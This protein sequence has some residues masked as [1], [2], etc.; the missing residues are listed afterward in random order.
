MNKHILSYTDKLNESIGKGSVLLIK[1]KPIKDGRYLYVTT[2]N[3]W[4]EIKPGIKMVFI[5]DNI[6]RVIHKG[7][8][9]FS[10]RKVQIRDEESLKGVFNMKNPGK[11][12]LVLN[13]NKTPFHWMTLKHTD[14]GTALRELGTQLFNHEMILESSQAISKEEENKFFVTELLKKLAGQPSAIVI[15]EVELEDDTILEFEDAASQAEDSYEDDWNVIF[16]VLLDD[17]KLSEPHLSHFSDTEKIE[18]EWEVMNQMGVDLEIPDIILSFNTQAYV[19]HSRDEGDYW[20]PPSSET[21]VSDV[22]TTLNISTIDAEEY[23]KLRS[24]WEKVKS[25][26]QDDDQFNERQKIA[27]KLNSYSFPYMYDESDTVVLGG[28]QELKNLISIIERIIDQD[29][30]E[31]T[32]SLFEG[33][34]GLTSNSDKLKR[35]VEARGKYYKQRLDLRQ[36]GISEEDKKKWINISV[37]YAKSVE[38]ETVKLIEQQKEMEQRDTNDETNSITEEDIKRSEE[39]F[40]WLESHIPAISNNTY[41]NFKYAQRSWIESEKSWKIPRLHEKGVIAAIGYLNKVVQDP[42]DH[43]QYLQNKYNYVESQRAIMTPDRAE[44]ESRRRIQEINV[45]LDPNHKL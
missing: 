6:F 28:A 4:V 19:T 9:K 8:G 35:N 5:S 22:E 33:L 40:N 26:K 3:G 23:N 45:F 31:E 7:D 38:A 27:K 12:S 2:I 14:I 11:P 16:K 43:M 39:I 1:G 15:K 20:T 18:S 29:L 34:A 42:S 32:F 13:H 41:Q 21:E 25:L 30:P 10:G 44:E 36:K 17:S 37:Q 24:E